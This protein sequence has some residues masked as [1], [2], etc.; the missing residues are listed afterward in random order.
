MLAATTLAGV[1]LMV[2]IPAFLIPG[3]TTL[4]PIG[5]PSSSGTA[6]STSESPG[7]PCLAHVFGANLTSTVTAAEEDTFTTWPS[8]PIA[9]S[10]AGKLRTP[11]VPPQ[12][13]IRS[14]LS[15]SSRESSKERRL[16]TMHALY[17]AAWSTPKGSP[18][19]PPDW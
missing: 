6:R 12:R 17:A 18:L 5:A 16:L 1:V 8:S 14:T 7:A 3:I 4:A 10:L 9:R 15:Q 19:L 13:S 2:T 11:S